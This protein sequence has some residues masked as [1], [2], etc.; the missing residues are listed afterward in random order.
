VTS[1]FAAKSVPPSRGQEVGN[2][3]SLKKSGGRLFPAFPLNL[4]TASVGVRQTA[5]GDCEVTGGTDN[6]EMVYFNNVAVKLLKWKA[7]LKAASLC[8]HFVQSMSLKVDDKHYENTRFT[9]RQPRLPLPPQLQFRRDLK[10][11]LFQSSYHSVQ[12]PE[13]VTVTFNTAGAPVTLHY[14]PSQYR[15]TPN[16]IG[17]RN[18][19]TCNVRHIV[20]I[21]YACHKYRQEYFTFDM[22]SDLWLKWVTKFESKFT[23]FYVKVLLSFPFFVCLF[24]AILCLLYFV[25][26]VPW[27][28]EI[29]IYRVDQKWAA[30][31][32]P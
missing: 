27:C 5:S 3:V 8:Q 12:L 11:A 19:C 9:M 7:C 23:D 25:L 16:S 18:Y 2:S 32:R 14:S 10:T 20:C 21:L 31:S 13:T 22:P 17:L 6:W 1:D 26:L 28:G 15:H 29:K 30:D 24:C 4:I